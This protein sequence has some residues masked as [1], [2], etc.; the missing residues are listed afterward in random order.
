[1]KPSH[2]ILIVLMKELKKKIIYMKITC[3]LNMSG[4]SMLY[5]KHYTMSPYCI[6]IPKCIKYSLD[7]LATDVISKSY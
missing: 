4:Q 1:M 5:Y 6:W 3:A 7:V 2:F